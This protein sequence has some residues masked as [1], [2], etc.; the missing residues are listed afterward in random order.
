MTTV[1]TRRYAARNEG[2]TVK[3]HQGRRVGH[4]KLPTPERRQI[5]NDQGKTREFKDRAR[6]ALCPPSGIKRMVEFEG[7][8]K[9]PRRA[10]YVCSENIN[11]SKVV[12]CDVM[13]TVPKGAWGT[14][15]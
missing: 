9:I 13:L 15:A 6:E 8:N 12:I 1:A 11:I 5:D 14:C 2:S 4:H 7:S 10:N 3:R